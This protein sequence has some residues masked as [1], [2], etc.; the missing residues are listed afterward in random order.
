MTDAADAS[1]PEPGADAALGAGARRDRRTGQIALMIVFVL[2]LMAIPTIVFVLVI[3]PSGGTV[4]YTIPAGTGARVAAGEKVD[5]MPTTIR[6]KVGEHLVIHNQDSRSYVVG[7]IAVRPLETVDHRFDA[8]G[9]FVG[10]CALGST[11]Q[12][13]VVVT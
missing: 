5:I 2:A 7:P 3:G 10:E 1:G 12:L 11:D 13:T 4:S 9:T 6:L 8:P